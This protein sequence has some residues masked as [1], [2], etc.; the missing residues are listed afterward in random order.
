MG[1]F[2]RLDTNVRAQYIFGIEE[3]PWTF[4]W[5]TVMYLRQKPG[6][7]LYLRFYTGR[8]YYNINF[9]TQVT[10]AE[11]GVTFGWDTLDRVVRRPSQARI[12]R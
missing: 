8:D 11:F 3:L 12:G 1:I 6:V 10:R 2:D 7:G 9:E 5:E 4:T